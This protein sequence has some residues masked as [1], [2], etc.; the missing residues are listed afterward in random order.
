MS[1]ELKLALI[2]IE[3]IDEYEDTWKKPDI[4]G[5]RIFSAY[6]ETRP[7]VV[8]YENQN[9]FVNNTSWGLVSFKK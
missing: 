7:E 1:D 5:T 9:L 2:D 4:E 3:N 8:L 6:L